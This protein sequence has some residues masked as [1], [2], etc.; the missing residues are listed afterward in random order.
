L[1]LCEKL[2]SL[3]YH[4]MRPAYQVDI[5]LFEEVR[6]YIRAKYETDSSL[7]FAPALQTFFWIGPEKIAEQPLV[8]HFNGPDNFKDLL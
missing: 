3:L 7:V 4:L 6:Y 5:L 1:T 8:R 2:V